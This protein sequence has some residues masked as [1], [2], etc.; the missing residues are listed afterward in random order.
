MVRQAGLFD[1]TTL[2]ALL[3]RGVAQAIERKVTSGRRMRVDTT[4]V[5]ANIAHPTDSGLC[6]A[7]VGVLSAQRVDCMR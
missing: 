7:A 1:E 2:R 6:A 5:E 3:D 4:V